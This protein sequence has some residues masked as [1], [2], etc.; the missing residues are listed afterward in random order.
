MFR[1]NDFIYEVDKKNNGKFFCRCI[2]RKTEDCSARVVV[3]KDPAPKVVK[4]TG[5]HTHGVEVKEIIRRTAKDHMK[6]LILSRPDRSYKDIYDEVMASVAREFEP[7]YDSQMIDAA[8]PSFSGVR[9]ALHPRNCLGVLRCARCGFSAVDQ[10][11]LETHVNLKECSKSAT[12]RE[13]P[14]KLG[15]NWR[16]WPKSGLDSNENET[17]NACESGGPHSCNE[18]TKSFKTLIALQNHRDDDHSGVVFCPACGHPL[19]SMRLL[20]LHSL[21]HA[22]QDPNEKPLDCVICGK[23]FDLRSNLILHRRRLIRSQGAFT[24]YYCHVRRCNERFTQEIDLIAHTKSSH[25]LESCEL[26]A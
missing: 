19:M 22:A 17:T 12:Q 4:L 10:S 18:C 6:R 2:K 5:T 23:H 16:Q 26:K 25:S 24:L 13:T 9:S 20:K 14:L 11:V 3:V 21:T 8:L 15:P 7:I 1:V